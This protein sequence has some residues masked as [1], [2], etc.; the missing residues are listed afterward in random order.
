VHM[1]RRMVVGIDR[2]PQAVDAQDRWHGAVWRKPKRLGTTKAAKATRTTRPPVAIAQF[3]I[4]ATS[5]GLCIVRRE[6][7][8]VAD[9]R[10]FRDQ[11]TGRLPRS[12]GRGAGWRERRGA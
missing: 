7:S 3:A 10:L 11:R 1:R 9:S 2:D 5:R 8:I 6:N 12:F 4:F